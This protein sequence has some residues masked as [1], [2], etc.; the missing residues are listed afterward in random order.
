MS[1]A[2]RRADGACLGSAHSRAGA[3]PKARPVGFGLARLN[4]HGCCARYAVGQAAYARPCALHAAAACTPHDGVLIGV[5]QSDLLCGSRLRDD[6]RKNPEVLAYLK[7]ENDY[8]AAVMSSTKGLQ[9]T[10][11]CAAAFRAGRLG[12]NVCGRCSVLQARP[13]AKRAVQWKHGLRPR[14]P[15]S[16]R[17]ATNNP[18]PPRET[19]APGPTGQGNA[20]AA[21]EQRRRRARAHRE[22]LVSRARRRTAGRRRAAACRSV[23]ARARP[24]GFAVGSRA[25]ASCAQA[26]NPPVWGVPRPQ[27]RQPH[28]QPQ[29]H[30]PTP[31]HTTRRHA[32]VQ[33]RPPSPREP[34][35]GTTCA[36]RRARTSLSARGAACRRAPSRWRSATAWTRPPKRRSCSTRT[37]ARRSA[38]LKPTTCA[39]LAAGPWF[40]APLLGRDV[41]GVGVRR[42]VPSTH[43]LAM[44]MC[45][46]QGVVLAA[47][48][49]SRCATRPA[50][51]PLKRCPAAAPCVPTLVL[52]GT[53]PRALPSSC[54]PVS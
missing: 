23:F 44:S 20:V 45:G 4:A 40:A 14:E 11:A 10:A 37:S 26:M 18:C 47:P 5:E 42:R 29:F 19:G 49:A 34:H 2:Q 17:H 52:A 35:P 48:A 30:A 16:G 25:R 24:R 22:F 36:R 8:T 38:S 33:P 7:K 12:L 32:P 53:A 15:C 27:A 21:R 39:P 3:A 50:C 43:R 28:T 41:C 54:L 9:V 31:V 13:A 1:G 51:S 46:A 6:S